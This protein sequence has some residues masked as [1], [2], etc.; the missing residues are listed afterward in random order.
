MPESQDAAVATG[1][2]KKNYDAGEELNTSN[3]RRYR[4]GFTDVAISDGGIS[5]TA[6]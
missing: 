5:S 6:R 3:S 4:N 2:V 1:Q